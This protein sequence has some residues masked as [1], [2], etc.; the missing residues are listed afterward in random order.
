MWLSRWVPPRLSQLPL[1]AAVDFL[2][3]QFNAAGL[4]ISL[5]G[6]GFL[7]PQTKGCDFMLDLEHLSP[8]LANREKKEAGNINSNYRLPSQHTSSTESL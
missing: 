2:L 1:Q 5:R 3:K 7:L 6:T 8:L 4:W